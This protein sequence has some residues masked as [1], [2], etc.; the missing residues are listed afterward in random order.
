SSKTPH[1]KAPSQIPRS[2]LGMTPW[3]LSLRRRAPR[4]I[5]RDDTS[6]NPRKYWKFLRSDGTTERRW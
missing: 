4:S 2:T 6:G 3:F 5:A 1:R